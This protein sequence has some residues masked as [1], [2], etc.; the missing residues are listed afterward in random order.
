M[1]GKRAGY[2]A[3]VKCVV[4]A[5]L[6]AL[7]LAGCPRN[8][9]ADAEAPAATDLPRFDGVTL[10]YHGDG[11][12]QGPV[13]ERQLAKRFEEATGAKVELHPQPRTREALEVYMA[14]FEAMDQGLD[15]ILLDV[16][17]PGILAP[18]LRDLR[19]DLSE[20][21]DAM[22]PELIRNDTIGGRLVAMPF[23]SDAG[24]L[25]FRS[26]LLDKHGFT[27]PPKS[28]DELE[29][30]ASTIQAAERHQDRAFAGF[31]FQGDTYEG[32]TCNA[33]EWQHSHGGGGIY[34][35]DTG[36]VSVDNP[37]AVRAFTRA[38][39]WIG[40]ISP[41]AVL[42]YQEED[43]RKAFQAGHAAFMR[44]WPYAW[45]EAAAAGSPVAGKIGVAPLPRDRE[46]T[47][48][49]ACLGGWQLGV[50]AYSQHPD[51]A[52][53]FVKYL[54]SPEV[55]G[56]RARVGS[57][58][59]AARDAYN[60]PALQANPVFKVM[61]EVLEQVVVRPSSRAREKYQAVSG[62][63]QRGVAEILKGAEPK[64]RLRALAKELQAL[65]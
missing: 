24:L 50:S 11:V 37:R 21:A 3:S 8:E 16:I 9:A 15:V 6:A 27:A 18:H 62:V 17:W 48:P 45:A 46:D 13:L 36:V 2:A 23:F 38:A 55:Q 29:R 30:Q 7:L 49:A 19:L 14:R 43:C 39:G 34:S 20:Q 31:L 58:L 51:A 26:D 5:L 52:I 41:R 33:V 40:G 22:F 12:G 4:A 42:G 1:P 57:Y 61:P 44:N 32:L 56:W 65:K 35:D 63:Y 47:R 54:A 59:P 28:W 10:Q 60:D 53:A 25:Y 64:T